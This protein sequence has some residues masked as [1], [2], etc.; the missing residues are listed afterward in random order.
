MLAAV[1]MTGATVAAC[2]FRPLYGSHQAAVNQ[3]TLSQVRIAPLPD[4]N[5]QLLYTHLT[6]AMHPRGGPRDPAWELAIDLREQ[7]QNLGIRKDETATRANLILE[8]WF[9]LKDLRTG[10]VAFKGRSLITNS[11][12]I[13][14]E[15]FG[16][17]ASRSDARTRA[18]RELGDNIS[19]R[20]AIFLSQAKTASTAP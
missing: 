10:K 3:A 9:Q 8:A 2:G 15:R 14:Q 18:I 7:T 11:Y 12:N 4:R 1:A 20:V 19:T 17:I 16:T 13:L 5:G 6:K